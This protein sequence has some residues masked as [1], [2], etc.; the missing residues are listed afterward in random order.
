MKNFNKKC[1]VLYSGGLDSLLAAAIMKKKGFEVNALFVQTPFY[2]K[3]IKHLQKQLE[4]FSCELFIKSNHDDYIEMVKNP[5]FGY[6]KNLNPCID[7]KIFFY[8]QAKKLID[9]TNS[10]FVVTGEVLGQR[11]MSQRSYSILRSIEKRADLTDLVFRPLSAKCLPKTEMESVGILKSKDFYCITGRG[12][13]EQFEI[14]RSFNINSFESPAGGCLLTDKS[15]SVR[16]KEMLMH[17]NFK[18][19]ELELLNIGRHF[20][21]N[22]NR[23][24]V[25]RNKKETQAMTEKFKNTQPFLKCKDAPGAVGVFMDSPST[26]EIELAASI[27]KRYSKKTEHIEYSYKNEEVI[28]KP[29][30]LNET[31]INSYKIK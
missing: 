26:D 2:K 13:K 3:D 31:L 18:E 4:Q 19:T 1:V 7:C 28:I 30:E 15:I 9:E 27:I 10:S 20:R 11:P 25:S 24:V 8:R 12:R 16:I 21:I 29:Q 17:E 23:F 14:A 22:S 5:Q 6:G